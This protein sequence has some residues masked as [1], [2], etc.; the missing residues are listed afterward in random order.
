[1]VLVSV[2]LRGQSPSF[3]EALGSLSNTRSKAVATFYFHL[4]TLLRRLERRTPSQSTH[5][6]TAPSLP[7]KAASFPFPPSTK[8]FHRLLELS[9]LGVVLFCFVFG[10]CPSVFLLVSLLFLR[11][12]NPRFTVLSQNLFCPVFLV[13]DK[14][15]ISKIIFLYIDR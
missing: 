11:A 5:L 7:Y 2:Y 8:S 4:Q 3:Y 9:L 1:M 13:S 14:E 12:E 15:S 10:F 6:S